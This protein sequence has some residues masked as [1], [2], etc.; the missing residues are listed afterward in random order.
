MNTATKVLKIEGSTLTIQKMENEQNSTI[1]STT[2]ALQILLLSAQLPLVEQGPAEQDLF[3]PL[4]E[5]T[6]FPYLVP[7]IRLM[8]WRFT[9]PQARLIQILPKKKYVF[10][11]WSLQTYS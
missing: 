9:F 6:I 7:E 8:I 2:F 5:F 3:K 4:E 11:Q 1:D 10:P